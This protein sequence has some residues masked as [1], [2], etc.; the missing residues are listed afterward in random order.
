M[1]ALGRKR[2][3]GPVLASDRR[4]WPLWVE[5]GHSKARIWRGIDTRERQHT[6]ARQVEAQ[7]QAV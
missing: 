1:T 6:L 7:N 2:T 4:E 5:S 3:F